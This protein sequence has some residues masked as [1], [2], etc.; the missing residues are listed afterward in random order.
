MLGFVIDFILV[1]ELCRPY[2]L[3]CYCIV[4]TM[5]WF[6][7]QGLNMYCALRFNSCFMYLQFY[8]LWA[9]YAFQVWVLF[10]KLNKPNGYY[11]LV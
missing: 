3:G 4:W 1:N 6:E 5:W 8:I 2:E 11:F 7:F 10:F 9:H